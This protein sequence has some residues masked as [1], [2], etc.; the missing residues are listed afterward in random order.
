[1]VNIRKL[2]IRDILQLKN[3]R[4]EEEDVSA[5]NDVNDL[6]EMLHNVECE[7]TSKSQNKKILTNNEGLCDTFL[8]V[9]TKILNLLVRLIYTLLYGYIGK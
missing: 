9:K 5:D 8:D 7:F 3:I 1:M 6:D 4:V 2:C